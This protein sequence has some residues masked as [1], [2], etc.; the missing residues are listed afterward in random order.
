MT[1]IL[2]WNCQKGLSGPKKNDLL[3]FLSQNNISIALLQETTDQTSFNSLWNYHSL[4]QASVL[5][6]SSTPSFLRSDL[7]I[8]NNYN[9][10]ITQIKIPNLS[11]D[12]LC[13][14]TYRKCINTSIS[15]TNFITQ[16]QHTAIKLKSSGLPFIIGG[17][18]NLHS[19]FLGSNSDDNTTSQLIHLSTLYTPGFLNNGLPTRFPQNPLSHSNPSAIDLTIAHANPHSSI[20]FSNWTT[21][22][23][24]F[25]DH[26]RITFS[27]LDS[28]VTSL[29]STPSSQSFKINKFPPQSDP[30]PISNLTPVQ[31]TINTLITTSD[32]LFDPN[33]MATNLSSILF[34]SGVA[35]KYLIPAPATS[36]IKSKSFHCNDAC[37]NL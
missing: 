19:T 21:H 27:I 14:S 16:I 1:N 22:P 17:D 32:T 35:H 2:Q 20:N 5:V 9:D 34:Q 23:P 28:A 15:R 11:C 25:S 3:H 7:S 10:L 37:A 4:H 36:Q 33:D 30:D 13:T 26:C 8:S 29:H 24:L 12:I 31:L 18:F 6:H